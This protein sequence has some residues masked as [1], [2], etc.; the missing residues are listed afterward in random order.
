[1]N[2][3]YTF[4]VTWTGYRTPRSKGEFHSLIADS[5]VSD[6]GLAIACSVRIQTIREWRD[7][8]SSPVAV[9]WRCYARCVHRGELAVELGDMTVENGRL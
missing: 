1:M 9:M 5:P 4:D 7:G 8:T 3:P 6:K 2:N